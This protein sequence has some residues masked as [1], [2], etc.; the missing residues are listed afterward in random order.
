[1]SSA[2]DPSGL[3]IQELQR[4]FLEHIVAPH[5]TTSSPETAPERDVEAILLPSA[6]LSAA[7][8]LG[9][10]SE[11]YILRLL[12]VV[13]NEHPG[14]KRLMGDDAFKELSLD[15]IDRYPPYG[16][17]LDDLCHAMP[18][19]L[20]HICER[21]DAALLHQMAR[22][23]NALSTAYHSHRVGTVTA[24]D[25]SQIPQEIWPVLRF[26]PGP[27]LHI[28]AFDF[29]V[30]DILD[31]HKEGTPLPDLGPTPTW[32]AVWRHNHKVWH[33]R[34]SRP[35]YEA[36]LALTSGETV[37]SALERASD[38]WEGDEEELAATVFQWFSEWIEEEFFCSIVLPPA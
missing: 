13:S 33:Q 3:S 25:L 38:V 31:A 30:I 11:Q 21:E 14:V 7:Q 10:Y 35:R 12:D 29:N 6:T 27:S 34:I 18:Y 1:M 26:R 5:R 24:E 9:V 20:K 15:Y 8:R 36:L 23:E 16:Y 2:H 22:F 28:M 17:S 4:W 19:Y 37:T 32:G